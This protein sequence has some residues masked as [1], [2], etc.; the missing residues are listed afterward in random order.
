MKII[1]LWDI[2]TRLFHWL[3]VVAI[4]A[5]FITGILG[6]NA[7][8]WH[9]RLG[10]LVVGLVTFRVV[11]GFVGSTYARFRQFVPGPASIAAYLKGSWHGPGHNPLGAFSVLALLALVTF[12]A[13]SGLF[14]NDEISFSGPLYRLVDPE[15]SLTLTSYHRVLAYVLLAFVGLHVASIVFYAIVKKDFLLIPMITGMKQVEAGESYRGGGIAPFLL[16][17]AIAAGA[18]YAASGLWAPEPPAPSAAEPVPAFD[19]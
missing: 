11:W 8:V 6:G 15:L 16:A 12:Q 18:I 2:P 19:F 9:G 4:V 3:L 17:L 13:I 10:I 14:T 7:I 1:K 5:L